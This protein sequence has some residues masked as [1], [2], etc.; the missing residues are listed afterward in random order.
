MP[1]READDT[2]RG[3]GR[4]RGGERKRKGR[5]GTRRVKIE[6][7]EEEAK[8]RGEEREGVRRRAPMPMVGFRVPGSDFKA[9][10]FAR[11]T[12]R[13]MRFVGMR[14]GNGSGSS[15][16]SATAT[17]PVKLGRV[18]KKYSFNLKFKIKLIY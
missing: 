13:R 2:F 10:P 18:L 7:E 8:K 16:R 5:K 15:T 12:R 4:R 11:K 6:E 17:G 3:G 9:S 1:A 14:E